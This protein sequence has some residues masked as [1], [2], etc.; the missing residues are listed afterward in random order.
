M[1]PITGAAVI[2][3]GASLAGGFMGANS[4]KA[5][6]KANL[7]MMR[8]NMAWQER[9]SNTAH[10]REAADLKAAGLNPILSLGSGA[11]GGSA[12]MIEQKPVNELEGLENA[13]QSAI[14]ARRIDKEI[15]AVESQKRVNQS[16]EA[17]NDA[18]RFNLEVDN[19]TK[20]IQNKM[21]Q[22]N[23]KELYEA[24][25]AEALLR[26]TEASLLKEQAE[27]DRKFLKFD[28]YEKRINKV[29]SGV[30]NATGVINPLNVLKGAK[31]AN[32]NSAKSTRRSNS[33]TEENYNSQGE[34]I[35]TKSRRY[36]D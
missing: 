5:A 12:Q 23:Q 3:A 17:K 35:G 36:H 14:E 33:Y 8:E 6:N 21:L 32:Q 11:S 20:I 34:H 29:I 2:G 9:M 26:K 24:G 16:Q 22:Q 18:E 7:K 1:D 30:S 31:N 25:K 27:Q 10:Q 28:N 13:A 19:S 4:A 15:E